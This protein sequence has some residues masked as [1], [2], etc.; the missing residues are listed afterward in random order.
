MSF[1]SLLQVFLVSDNLYTKG[2][3]TLGLIDLNL[4]LSWIYVFFVKSFNPNL[5]G[6]RVSSLSTSYHS[7]TLVLHREVGISSGSESLW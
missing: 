4:H 6:E 2:P 7:P 5:I 1:H 3:P